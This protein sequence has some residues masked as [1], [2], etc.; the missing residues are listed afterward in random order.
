MQP[1]CIIIIN[2]YAEYL[3]QELAITVGAQGIGIA[4]TGQYQ[5]AKSSGLSVSIRVIIDR[6]T[7]FPPVRFPPSLGN[8]LGG[9]YGK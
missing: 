4:G 7:P 3:W 9:I 1:V 2:R 8:D 5:R 6:S